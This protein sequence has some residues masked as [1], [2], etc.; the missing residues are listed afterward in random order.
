MGRHKKNKYGNMTSPVIESSGI[1]N[2]ETN[3]I[4]EEKPL[5]KFI[6]P[7]GTPS[8]LVPSSRKIKATIYKNGKKVH[9]EKPDLVFVSWKHGIFQTSDSVVID[10]IENVKKIKRA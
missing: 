10:Y 1:Q 6:R 8:F 5:I 3:E 2:S 4:I 7:N 9:F